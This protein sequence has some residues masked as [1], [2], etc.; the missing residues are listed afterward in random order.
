MDRNMGHE[1]VLKF[2]KAFKRWSLNGVH[3]RLP[4]WTLNECLKIPQMYPKAY[5]GCVQVLPPRCREE[6]LDLSP[7]PEHS[8][9]S[10]MVAYMAAYMSAYI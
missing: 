2:F 6:K 1:S 4:E 10:K 3:P 8:S 7:Y 9:A 5:L